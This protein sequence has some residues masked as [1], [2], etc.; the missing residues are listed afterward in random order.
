[1]RWQ[2]GAA[3]EARAPPKG[4]IRRRRH[5]GRP[6]GAHPPPLPDRLAP[7]GQ[8]VTVLLSWSRRRSSVASIDRSMR[9]TLEQQQNER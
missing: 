7:W 1:M 6:T 3:P 8:P 4:P 9:G 5:V 2:P